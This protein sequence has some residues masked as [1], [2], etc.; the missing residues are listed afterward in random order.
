MS[1][2]LALAVDGGNSKTDL[3]LIR[4]DGAL[5]SV[6]R[7]PGSSQ[8]KLGVEGSVE[9]LG[10]LLGRAATEAGVEVNHQ[11]VAEVS[12]VMIAGADLPEEEETLQNALAD[13][14]WA[15][16]TEVANDTFAVLRTGTDRGWGVALVCG[17]GI[18]CVGVAE[19][20]RVARFAALGKITGDWGGGDDVGPDALWAAARSADGRGPKSTLER[21]VPAHFD[22]ETPLD[23]ARAIHFDQMPYGRLIELAPVVLAEASG[24]PVAREI[25]E[26]LKAEMVNLTRVAIERL[27]LHG[28]SF[29]VVLGGGMFRADGRELIDAVSDGVSEFAPEATVTAIDAHP[30]VG[31]ALLALDELGSQPAAKERIRQSLAEAG[32]G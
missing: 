31:A 28:E 29:E 12:R 4:E 30:I 11:P 21:A 13:Q 1:D 2:R 6:V 7:G 22:L 14:G 8:H 5:L 15:P 27:D 16:R 26:R 18:N 9:V 32:L 23:V 25:V 24:D 10:T 19:D 3:A 17:A 20:G